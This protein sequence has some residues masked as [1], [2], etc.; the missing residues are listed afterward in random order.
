MGRPYNAEE[1][2]LPLRTVVVLIGMCLAATGLFWTARGQWDETQNSIQTT[3]ASLNLLSKEQ[4]DFRVYMGDL[5]LKKGAERDAQFSKVNASMADLGNSLTASVAD[6]N[7]K[8]TALRANQDGSHDETVAAIGQ[9][10]L[11]IENIMRDMAIM[12]CKLPGNECQKV[13][14]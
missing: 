11:Q 8:I 5:I 12:K 14:P 13:K 3:Q 9:I 7:T 1:A 2:V 4:A 10:R 6:L